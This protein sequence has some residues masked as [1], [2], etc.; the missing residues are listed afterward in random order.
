M[1]IRF[2]K[3]NM[4]LQAILCEICYVSNCWNSIS[5]LWT[6]LYLFEVTPETPGQSRYSS[7]PGPLAFSSLHLWLLLHLHV[8]QEAGN[9]ASLGLVEWLQ[10]QFSE[11]I[12]AV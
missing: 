7:S 1:I 9:L 4:A 2:G 12:L 8:L 5:H 3:V 11:D 6:S 10:E